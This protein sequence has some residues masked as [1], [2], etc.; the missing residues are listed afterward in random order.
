[1][2]GLGL[3]QIAINVGRTAQGP[4]QQIADII[5]FVASPWGLNF[6][7][8]Q[9]RPRLFPVQIIILKA[10][11]GIELDDKVKFAIWKD[12]RQQ[13]QW[14]FT[15]REYLEYLF[16]EGR[17]SVKTVDHDRR[18]LVLAVGRRSGKCILGDSLVLTDQ[19][20]LRIE[21]LGDP[22]GDEVQPLEIGVAQEGSANARSRFFYNGGVKPV[23]TLTTHCGYHLGGTDSHRIKVLTEQGVVDW[24]YLSDIH[25]GDV[26]CLHRGTDLWSTEYVD[27]TPYHNN[28]GLKDLHFP[29]HLDEEWGR[30]LGYLVG[31]GLWNYPGRVEVTVEHDETWDTLK[32]LYRKLFGGFSVAMDK[33]T[34]NTGALKFCSVGMRQFLHDL[35]FRM[36]TE[37][38]A[39][40]VP[41]AILKSPRPVVQAFLRG[42]FETDGGVSLN[43]RVVEFS[44]AS[45]RLVHEV[46]T[47]LLN[48]GIVSRIRP[49]PIK[50][51]TY[52]VLTIRGLRHR[53]VF[54][55]LV[56]FDSQKKM[57]PLVASLSS[58]RE[59]G[60]T[61]SIPHQKEWVDRLLHSVQV[62]CPGKGWSRSLM[63]DALGSMI[64]PGSPGDLTYPRLAR[65]LPVAENLG[66]DQNV[67]SH[68]RDL[69]DQDYFFDPVVGI[70]ESNAPVFDLNVP[71]GESF[72][73]NGVVNH[74]TFLAAAISAY[75]TYKLL[76]KG[77]P[78]NYYGLPPGNQIGIVSVATDKEQAGILYNEVSSHFRGCQ[79]FAP[80]TANNTQSYARFQT[81]RDIDE[82]CRYSD[83]P[84]A[85]RATIK[86]SFKS[87]IAKGLRGPGN[88]VII[89][90]EAAHFIDAGQS[91]AEAVYNAI[92]PST[93]TFSPKDPNNTNQST[94]PV[95]GR[96][97]NISSPL[98]RAGQFYRLFQ[99]AMKG[100]TASD[101]ML[102]IQAPTWE[103]NP[104]LPPS[105][106]EK[107]YLK[108]PVVFY[109]EF[110]AEFSDRTRGWIDREQDLLECVDANHRPTVQAPARRPHFI[111]VDVGLVG[112]GSAVAIGHLESR[113][114]QR[115][116]VL[117]HI[118]QIKAGE[119][120]YKDKERLEF[121]DVVEW[122]YNISRRF[123]LA[124]GIFDQYAGIPFEQALYKKGLRQLQSEHMTRNLNSDIY[125]NFKD[126]LYDRRL[127]LF[128]WPPPTT[129]ASP[130]CPYIQELLELQVETHTK[131]IIEV[132][133]PNMEGK[134]DDM[135]DALVRMVWLAS[136]HLSSPKYIVGA[137]SA[138]GAS[139][140]TYSPRAQAAGGRRAFLQARQ[141]G[142]SPDRQRSRAN[143]GRIRGRY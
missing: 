30:L 50:G 93:A 39:K 60:D 53:K 1:M 129:G 126:M 121:D 75:E 99:I 133:A 65:V 108:D 16:N 2:G 74:N 6:D 26:V 38:D 82:T 142:T 25:L 5:E 97:I 137:H 35:G 80:Y 63:R 140:G 116:I 103:V 59:G 127:V 123:Y 8:Q 107:H 135:S 41:W 87:C 92:T 105:E 33:R 51:R 58:S 42:L 10:H 67:L 73:A 134:H 110:G 91:S 32:D 24:K 88:I 78:Q 55:D 9:G 46:Q 95:E 34:E 119:G 70:E 31:G 124:H 4:S 111:G 141:M 109:T 72:V 19:G 45:S 138:F 7:G 76:L 18:E 112:D 100:G 120:E 3:G 11:Y 81:P 113:G 27:C 61:E 21:D 36:G 102:A 122:V 84:G 128:N 132:K 52:W 69:V 71:D 86:V 66:A 90:D 62:A 115:L 143:P 37:R 114:D 17:S 125:R 104:T 101:T 22:Y 79:F 48:L 12:W 23:R 14:Q 118:D 83:D 106:Y 47:L 28:R 57:S 64:K 44:T 56:G 40:M 139:P 130:H 43:G 136:K 96:I 85:A 13:D 89:L 68:F 117:D 94:G 15:E 20:V 54:A 29:E 49:K 77:S 98:G 131:Y